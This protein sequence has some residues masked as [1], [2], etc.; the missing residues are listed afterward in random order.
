MPRLSLRVTPSIAIVPAGRGA[1]TAVDREVRVTVANHGKGA[2]QG[3]VRMDVPS[4]W[5]AT[6]AQAVNFTREDE[7]QTVRF[8]LRPAA[9]TALGQYVVKSVATADAQT[10]NTGFQVVEYPHIQRQQLELPARCRQGN[11][12]RLAANLNVGYVMGTGDDVPASFADWCNRAAAGFGRARVERPE[13]LQRDLHRR[14]AYDSVMICAPTTS[15]F[16]TTP[17]RRYR[18]R[19]VQPENTWTQSRRSPWLQ[20]HRVTD[21]TSGA[22]LSA[23]DSVFHFRTDRRAAW[24][25]WVQ[26]RGTYFVPPTDERTPTSSRIQET[27]EQ[28]GG[29]RAPCERECRKGRWILCR[30]RIVAP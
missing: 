7:A 19:P 8:T 25:N 22:I 28:T 15:A 3:Q 1:T 13:P 14:R 18:R 30:A 5:T 24:R 20:Q 12:R 27:S 2:A 23:D 29:R 10:F 21:E 26:E 4:G 17:L 9:K 16:S 6:P 11:G